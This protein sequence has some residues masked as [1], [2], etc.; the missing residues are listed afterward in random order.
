LRNGLLFSLGA[1]LWSVQM[2]ILLF[3]S[4]EQKARYLP[5]LVAGETI[6]GHAVSEAEA[7]SD[8]FSLRRTA[9]EDADGYILDGA[10][11]WV[12]SGPHADVFLV[13][14][15]L[16]PTQGAKALTAF[17]VDRDTPG[18]GLAQTYEKMGLR[19][20]TIGELVLSNCLVPATAMLGKAGAGST[21]FGVAMEWERTFILVPALGTMRRQ[22]EQCVAHARTRRQFGAP[23]GRKD[24]VSSKL[25]EMHLR[26]E[27]SR[28][29]A[30]RAAWAKQQGKRMTREPSEVKLHLSESWVQT[31]LDA[32]QINGASGYMSELGIERDLRDALASKIYSGTS[33]IQRM[34]IASFLGV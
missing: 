3:G 20:A 24:A 22:L 8:V 15:T 33:E 31:S 10:K 16:D 23:I 25:A 32:L 9:V 5:R 29:L 27:T 11:S 12:T 28:L 1:Q 19:T 6:G 26:L 30:Y 7:G 18:V 14:A 21:I 34:I 4:E 2:P 13:L 17:L